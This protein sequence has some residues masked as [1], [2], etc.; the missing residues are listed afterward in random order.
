MD[1]LITEIQNGIKATNADDAYSCGMRNG[2]RWCISLIDDKEPLYENCPSA[3]PEIIKCNACRHWHQTTGEMK[4]FGLG[5]CDYLEKK[6]V[7]CNGYCYWAETKEGLRK[8]LPE[9]TFAAY[10]GK[11]E[12]DDKLRC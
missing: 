1:D 8:I 12:K 7:T 9:D 4:G 11:E 6:L 3:Q 10:Y 2:M 5:D